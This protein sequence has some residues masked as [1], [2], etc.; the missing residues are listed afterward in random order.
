MC[1]ILG[2]YYCWK[3]T[4]ILIVF[5]AIR[6][7]FVFLAGLFKNNS[8]KKYKQTSIMARSFFTECI[9]NTKSVFSHNFKK[10]AIKLYKSIL[11][12]LTF[13]YLRDSIFLGIF[14]AAINCLAYP[15][16]SVAYKIGIKLIYKRQISFDQLINAKRN[17]MS[18]IDGELYFA[19]RGFLD[20]TKIIIAYKY[21]L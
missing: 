2:F 9:T 15:A 13:D 16:N 3:I 4:L 5:F 8:R 21:I 12:S 6:I 18:I 1:L 17:L 19:I 11:N 7:V 14:L 10:E 20:F